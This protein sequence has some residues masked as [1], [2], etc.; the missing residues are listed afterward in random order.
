MRYRVTGSS[1][2]HFFSSKSD[3][4]PSDQESTK[5]VISESS[6]YDASYDSI[7]TF[8]LTGAGICKYQS[9][10]QW[11]ISL[12]QDATPF[13]AELAAT[14]DCVTSCLRKR[15]AKE[16][17]IC[18]DSQSALAALAVGGTKSLLVAD[19]MEKL[20]QFYQK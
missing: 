9:K 10:T 11:H 13:Q 16:I 2:W 4:F 15:P 19:C 5:P 20:E 3:I 1:L 14:L 7:I 18:I 17:T 12:G 6:S 8:I